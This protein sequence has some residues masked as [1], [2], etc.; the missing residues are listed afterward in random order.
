MA[1]T[2]RFALP[3]GLRVVLDYHP[4]ASMA[5]V[6]TLYDVGARDEHPGHR[7]MAH[8]FEHLMFGG[9]VNIPDFDAPLQSAGGMSNAWT[10]DDY[11]NFYD[12][13]P[14]HNIE[15][16]LWLESDRMLSLSF[17][18]KALEVQRSVVV[19]E[20]KQMC[21]NRPYGDL[22]HHLHR[23][24]FSGT[25]YATPVIGDTFESIERTTN[26]DVKHWFHSH[27]APNNAILSVVG[28]ITPDRLQ[29]LVEKWYADI[30]S[31]QIPRRADIRF[32]DDWLSPAPA[33][34]VTNAGVA[35]ATS[36]GAATAIVSGNV[37][38]TLITIAYPMPGYGQP[39]YEA[40]DLITDIL[41]NG[42]SSR[43]YRRLLTGSDMFASVDASITGTDYP[44][45]IMITATLLR[46]GAQAEAEAFSAIS[47]ELQQLTTI[48]VGEAEL[49]RTLNR[50]ESNRFFAML[51]PLE[52]AQSL[53]KCELKGETLADITARYRAVSAPMLRDVA[54]RLLR[55]ELARTLIYRPKV[56]G[57]APFV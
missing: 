49:T 2:F 48:E 3:N 57:Y 9:S 5:V 41:A 46:N 42:K 53:A 18:E 50:V 52:K 19:E 44:G 55:P 22:S 16:A 39:G 25:P 40:A 28:N 20:F 37:P 21:L 23:L 33:D 36:T 24:C 29:Q 8:L 26:E 45:I 11:T 6:N 51:S 15:T 54:S 34:T 1:E 7:G 56:E 35:T 4:T 14:V 13:I 32:A 31:R 38:N 12:I 27:Y 43:F 10:S 47:S 17:S 30:P